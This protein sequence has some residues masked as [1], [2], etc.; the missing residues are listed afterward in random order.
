MRLLYHAGEQFLFT[1]MTGQLCNVVLC[2]H[3]GP[4]PNG[5]LHYLFFWVV[6]SIVLQ[7]LHKYIRALR[8]NIS[9]VGWQGCEPGN[10]ENLG[11]VSAGTSTPQWGCLWSGCPQNLPNDPEKHCCQTKKSNPEKD[12][13]IGRGKFNIIKK[14]YYRQHRGYLGGQNWLGS[15]VA[16]PDPI[17]SATFLSGRIR[18]DSSYHKIHPRSG[19][20]TRSDLF[21]IKCVP[22]VLRYAIWFLK[23]AKLVL[24]L[25]DYLH[26][27]FLGKLHYNLQ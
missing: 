25:V 26:T 21:A 1:S 22:K 12:N 18:K 5:F 23:V 2:W 10:Q 17:G 16:E 4:V 11:W 24:D 20:E 7:P 19:F 27:C 3:T 6:P 13:K 8:N 9:T 15:S 14:K